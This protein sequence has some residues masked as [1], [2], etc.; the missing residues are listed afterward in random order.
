M[1]AWASYTARKHLAYY[2]T[3][4]VLLFV[5]F[6]GDSQLQRTTISFFLHHKFIFFSAP[7]FLNSCTSAPQFHFFLLILLC[8]SNVYLAGAETTFDRDLW[9]SGSKV[10]DLSKA[11]AEALPKSGKVRYAA[12]RVFLYAAHR[13]CL[14]CAHRL[15]RLSAQRLTLL[16]VHVCLCIS[17]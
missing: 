13:L 7:Q 16:C 15:T 2:P 10:K 6:F 8:D 4:T 1:R 17:S 11:D 3:D 12:R 5:L 14:L 9:I